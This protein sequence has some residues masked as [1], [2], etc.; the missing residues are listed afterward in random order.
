MSWCT[1]CHNEYDP[2]TGVQLRQGQNPT[3]KKH[4]THQCYYKHLHVSG[5]SQAFV[6]GGAQLVMAGGGG[7]GA[8]IGGRV[9][10]CNYCHGAGM[11]PGAPPHD[12][13]RCDDLANPNG[14]AA[15]AARGGQHVMAGRGAQNF[16]PRV[17]Q[18]GGGGGAHTQ[19]RLATDCRTINFYGIDYTVIKIENKGAKRY[20]TFD[21]DGVHHTTQLS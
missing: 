17:V 16:Q 13:H 21:H 15:L 12:T 4:K 6:V 1:F 18:V 9:K 5:G 19:V 7:R 14:K 8:P 10:Q 20:V 3:A 2:H 11:A